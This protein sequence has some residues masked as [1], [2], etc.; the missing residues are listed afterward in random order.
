METIAGNW[1][2]HFKI[3]EAS[4]PPG[5]TKGD[6]RFFFPQISDIKI[7]SEARTATIPFHY[8]LPTEQEITRFGSGSKGQQAVL[9]DA[10]RSI[11]KTTSYPLLAARLAEV[12]SQTEKETLTLLDK[13]LRHFARKNTADFFVHKRLRELLIDE[14][15]FY[16]RDQVVHLMDAE[17][18]LST[19]ERKRLALRVFRRLAE[20][21]IDFLARIE[22]A[23]KI[24]FE[25]KK[26]ALTVDYLVPIRHVPKEFWRET[27]DCGAQI[28]QW[29][30]WF[31]INPKKDLFNQKG[32]I[33]E[34]FLDQHPTLTVD[35][36]C[37]DSDFKLRLLAALSR[38]FADLEE[39][40]DGLLIHSENLQALNYLLPCYEGQVKCIYIDPPYNTG[41][42]EFLYKDK[43]QDSSW[44]AMLQDRSVFLPVILRRD[45]VFFS[46][47][48]D[49]EFANLQRHLLHLFGKRNKLGSLVW[50]GATDNNPTR[51]A[52]EHEYLLCFARDSDAL[53]SVW[54]NSADETKLLM[55]E[56]YQELKKLRKTPELIQRDFRVW[57]KDNYH[58]LQPLTHYD[59]VDSTGPYTGGR[60]V[61][62]PGKEGYRYDVIHPVTGKPCKQPTRGYR[63]PEP[64][65]KDL[66]AQDRIIFGKD[67]SQIIQIKEYLADY[68]GGLKGII[69]L[70]SR[71]ATNELE[72]IFGS[73]VVFKN[74]K[75]TTLLEHFLS[76]VSD[77]NALLMDFFAG[78]G[79]T[80]HA[81]INLNREDGGQRKFILVEMGDYFNT[82]L[83]PRIAKVMYT[84]EWKDGKPKRMATDQEAER[85]PRL[86]KMLKLESYENALH[87]L[88]TEKQLEQVLEGRE[89]GGDRRI[90]YVLERLLENNGSMLN[91]EALD[92]PFEYTIEILTGEGIKVSPV[93]LVETFNALY[94]LRVQRFEMWTDPSTKREYRVI[95]ARKGDKRRVL[96]IW[97]NVPAEKEAGADRAFL[98]KQIKN[99][100]EWDEAWVNGPCAVPG[101]K[102]LDGLFKRLIAGHRA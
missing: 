36:R 64:R 81:V 27:L 44:L 78:S 47:I 14:L 34:V 2:L 98:E 89:P 1:R 48:D 63:Y 18:D 20:R 65:M 51:I 21:I 93:D 85:T 24:L 61:H 50:K 49:T 87:N 23:Q 77:G 95:K 67:H 9:D 58:S 53:P 66:I 97:R 68:E 29:K 72:S 3:V 6:T 100:A 43:Y 86:V 7:D 35:T 15:E 96:V 41:Q 12:V 42:D 70:D 55:L 74:P 32:E 91:W 8:R 69:Q 28:T 40:T 80:A 38:H 76:F 30:D 19:L 11:L 75:P 94:G 52:I 57:I 37:F 33:N 56:K 16:I 5:N 10:A 101:L 13:R 99:L 90:A 45:G 22:D 92:R 84:P 39:A 46:S 73:R 54:K 62:N 88:T 4:T 59:R 26:F 79:T 82:V 102:P 17:A 83:V 25:K 31:A 60:K 71:T